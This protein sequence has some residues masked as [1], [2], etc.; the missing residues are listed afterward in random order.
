MYNM[1]IYMLHIYNAVKMSIII[2]FLISTRSHASDTTT[3]ALYLPS[4]YITFIYLFKPPMHH[5]VHRSHSAALILT[6]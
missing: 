5:G 4:R 6:K 2:I 1:Y 3:H